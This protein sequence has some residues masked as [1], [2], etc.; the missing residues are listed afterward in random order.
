VNPSPT[1]IEHACACV[2]ELHVY[3]LVLLGAHLCAFETSKYTEPSAVVYAWPLA[4]KALI[5][6]AMPPRCCDAR[7]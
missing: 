1:N 4:S 2:C 5:S 3:E 7:G 6:A